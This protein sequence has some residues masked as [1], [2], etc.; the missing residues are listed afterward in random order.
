MSIAL[1]TIG[2]AYE[3]G[4]IQRLA[5]PFGLRQEKNWAPFVHE[6]ALHFIY[7]FDPLIILRHDPARRKRVVRR[8]TFCAVHRR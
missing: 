2:Q 8:P 6:G 3:G 4:S 5:S 7:S 1:L